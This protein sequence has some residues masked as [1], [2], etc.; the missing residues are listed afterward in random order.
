[1]TKVAIVTDSSTCLPDELI[2]SHRIRVAPMAILI[3]GEMYDDG[4][5]SSREFYSLLGS[6]R[7][8]PTTAAPAPAAFLQAFKDA[9]RDAESVLCIT[10]S[11]KYSGSYSSALTALDL[12][13]EEQPDVPVRVVDSHSLAMCHGFTVLSAARAAEASAD[14]DEAEAVVREVASRAFLIGAID[15]LRYL[16]RSGRVPRFV[17]WATSLLRIKPILEACGDEV[18]AVARTRT[19]YRALRRM[20]SRAE[21]RYDGQ[22][23][24]RLAVMHANAPETAEELAALAR[25]SLQPDELLVTEFSSVMGVHAGPGFVGLAFFS[26]EPSARRPVATASAAREDDVDRLKA[27]LG[28]LPPASSHPS[29]VL[30]SGLPGSGKSHFSRELAARHPLVHLNIDMLRRTLFVRPAHDQPEHARL[31][32]AVHALIERLLSRG[33][34][35]VLDA[36]SLKRAH[37]LAAYEIAERT[38]TGL[39]VVRTEAPEDV[40]LHR[41]EGRSRGGD[42][43]EA[44]AEVYSKMKADMDPIERPHLRVDTSRDIEP[45]L[46]EVLRQLENV[47]ESLAT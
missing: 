19:M 4:R 3:D 21:E 38:G 47:S 13:K 16:A 25:E 28:E 10:L 29:L 40:T 18:H 43:S 1:M 9:A 23:P 12:A 37:R 45:A 31:F 7:D 42:A 15:T 26:G 30:V 2:R 39:I 46:A 24:L 41:L 35:V 33:V 17:H 22:R 8:L 32:A 44:T 6:S 34:S 14:L 20:V 27:S 11:S 5:L 36:T